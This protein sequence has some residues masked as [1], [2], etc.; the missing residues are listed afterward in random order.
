MT[1][2]LTK[3]TSNITLILICSTSILATPNALAINNLVS[4]TAFVNAQDI[5]PSASFD[6]RYYTAN[7]FVGK[8]IDA[9]KAP[10]CILHKDAVQALKKVNDELKKELKRLKVFDCYRP[11]TAVA[12]FMRWVD[13]TKDISTKAEYYP[14]LSKPLLKGEYIAEKSGHSRGYTVDLTIEY[15]T[16]DGQFSELDMGSPFDLFDEKS[17]TMSTLVTPKQTQN[18]LL[19]KNLMLKHGF[20]DYSMEWWH[21][22]HTTDPR[23]TYWD[24]PIK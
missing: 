24:F 19:L 11:Q 2:Y 10:K 13:D 9:Y 6:I 3:L 8:P 5:I 18:R 16:K 17:N 23:T 4:K 14:N 7:N 12:H 15:Q 1:Q 22:T 20:S 21:F